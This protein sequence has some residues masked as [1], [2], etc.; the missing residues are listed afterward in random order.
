MT[1]FTLN[2]AM[3]Y[4]VNHDIETWIHLFLNGEGDNVGLS[5]GLK[6]KR[7]YWLGPIEIDISYLDRVV[8]PESNMEYVEDEDWWNYNISQISNRIEVGWDMP[9]LIAEN[10]E[11]SLSIRDGNHR[12]GALQKL[13]KEKCFVVIWD[14]S[15][16]E[17]I[18]KAIQKKK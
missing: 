16:V 17:N 3:E 15:S 6:M 9:P 18:L 2:A 4:A 10:R 14:D 8:G 13:K 5:E 12:L 11:G 7:R 1:R